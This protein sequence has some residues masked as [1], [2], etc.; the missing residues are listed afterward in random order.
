MALAQTERFRKALAATHPEL[1]RPGAIEIVRI[2]TTADRIQ[3]RKLSEIGG[4][5]LFTKEIEEALL[6]GAIDLA[7][8]SMKDVPTLLPDGLE[9]ACIPTRDD[10]RDALISRDGKQ[11]TEFAPGAT[12]GTSSLRRQAQILHRRPDLRIVPFRGNANTRLRK[13]EAGVVDATI[14]AVS[15]LDRIDRLD[16]ITAIVPIDEILPAVGQGALGI[17]ILASN[18][19]VR[20]LLLPLNDQVSELCVRAERSFLA[21]LDGSCHTPIASLAT[22]SPDGSLFLRGLVASPDGR[23]VSQGTRTG[24]VSAGSEMGAQLGDE[25]RFDVIA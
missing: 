22:V 25:L 2:V 12:I 4:K 21:R 17:E 6:S 13:L 16:V 9:I 7:V 1:D 18:D 10:P 3:D 19:A 24:A 8:H 14:L 20:E 23:R 15:G 11:F 5:A